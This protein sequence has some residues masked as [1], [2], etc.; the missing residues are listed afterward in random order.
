M[1]YNRCQKWV[2]ELAGKVCPFLE[3]IIRSGY[4]NN[5]CKFQWYWDISNFELLVRKYGNIP[6][7]LTYV[8]RPEFDLV[9]T[10]FHFGSHVTRESYLIGS[11]SKL[12]LLCTALRGLHNL[13]QNSP[14]RCGPGHWAWLGKPGYLNVHDSPCQDTSLCMTPR[15]RIHHCAWLP[16][17][18][19]LT[20]Y[21]SLGHETSLSMTHRI[22]LPLCA[23]LTGS[24]G[25][26][27]YGVH[28]SAVLPVE[29]THHVTSVSITCAFSYVTRSWWLHLILTDIAL[30]WLSYISILGSPKVVFTVACGWSNVSH[31]SGIAKCTSTSTAKRLKVT[32]TNMATT[33][34]KGKKEQYLKKCEKQKRAKSKKKS[35]K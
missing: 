17:S 10:G 28:R 24:P 29:F 8:I 22:R 1:H 18:W 27:A 19:Y 32:E 3:Q 23:W 30:V 34:R 12:Q 16:L 14:R 6:V 9:I 7:V 25:S 20:M 13:C 31:V 15:A 11:L 35:E 26:H 4:F 21:D 2:I 33:V 5:K